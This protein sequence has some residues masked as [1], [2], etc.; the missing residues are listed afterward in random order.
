[1]INNLKYKRW[2]ELGKKRFAEEGIQGININH[3]SDEV[4]VA[5][6]SF[7]FFFKSREEYLEQ[8]FAYWVNE[9]TTKLITMV[10]RISDPAKRFL[11]IG[12]MIEENH[13]N[14]LFYYQLKLFAR[15]NAFARPY[16]DETDNQ[17]KN[18]ALKMFKD[19]GHSAEDAKRLW[20]RMRVYYMGMQALQMGYNSDDVFPELTPDQLLHF[21]EF[22]K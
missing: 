16:L 21:F 5:K 3:L 4:G 22:T 20:A 1:M 11:A 19:A 10:N 13:E 2:L 15:N 18:F 7:Y 6:T 17:R 12:K 14:E 8:L 9:G